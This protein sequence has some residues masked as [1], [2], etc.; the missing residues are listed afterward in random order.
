MREGLIITRLLVVV[1]HVEALSLLLL[2][3][4]FH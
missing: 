3:R 4:L 2:W 1:V